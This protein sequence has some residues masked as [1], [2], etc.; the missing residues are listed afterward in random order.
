MG[1]LFV[2]WPAGD[3]SDKT[4]SLPVVN[5]SK[6]EPNETLALSLSAFGA[7]K[8]AP[9]SS[10]L[11]IEDDDAVVSAVSGSGTYGGA[12]TL[13]AT[14]TLAGSP[15][16]GKSVAFT[17]NGVSVGSAATDAGGVATLS[18]VSLSGFNAGAQAGAVGAAFAGDA[19][20]SG[21]SATGPLSVAKA[22]Q[23]INFGALSDKTYGDADFTVSATASSGLSVSFGASGN[24]SVSGST[25]HIT[26]AGSCTITASQP[27]DSNYNAAAGVSRDFNIAQASTSVALS[28]SVNPSAVGQ[29]VT[30]T[31]TV[32]SPAGPAPGGVFGAVNFF[33]DGVAIPNCASL[34]NSGQAA[35]TTSTLTPGSHAITAEYSTTSQNFTGSSGGLQGGQTVGSLIEFAQ[36][37]YGVAEGESLTVTVTR[38][39][40]ASRAVSVDYATDDGSAPGVAVPC[41][42]VTGLALD[43]CDYSK[44]LGTLRFAP[45]ETEKT[46]VVL[47]GD[48][49]YAEGAET[50]SLKLS[51][52]SGG[53]ALG[54]RPA[55]VMTISDDSPE[56]ADS[57]I[58]DDENFVRQHYRDFLHRDPDAAGLAFWTNSIKSCGADAHCR[59]VRRVHAS[60]AFFLSIESQETGFFAY[61][62]YKAA[63]G[64]AASPDVPGAVPVI[65][66]EEFLP[67]AQL[68]GR[69]VIVGQGAWE[70]QLEANKQA[71]ALAFVSRQR[72]A[73][74]FPSTMS[75]AAFVSKL[76]ENAGGV[77]SPEESAR[78][79]AALGAA[80]SDASKRAS[81]FVQVAENAQLRQREF[82]RAFVL[83][84]YFGYLRRNPDDAPE[85]SRNF[86]G[87][88]FWLSKLDEF[89]GDFVQAE[90]VKA[91]ITSDE[92]RRRFG[93]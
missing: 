88:E 6:P 21:A 65:R 38:S 81:V 48:D 1:D 80:P 56:T 84:E 61:R 35:C 51:N 19:D 3:A 63:Y 50:A 25:V 54:P 57:P 58:D 7:T 53:S 59:E 75:A 87:W 89:D 34:L 33:D 23:T 71:F 68:V 39:G 69:D 8:G 46:F 66:F 40:D 49:S 9:A 26:G 76:D 28:S 64:D 15:L 45:G 70:Q 67:D 16:P 92:Y 24:C 60:A 13:E 11:T 18:G 2:T 91:F 74:A 31:A 10:T 52:P 77:L 17:L 73:D 41:S 86:A 90:L 82:S 4:V 27:G 14:L 79:V 83:M 29:S 44:A 5:D 62:A 37:A 72:F 30:F 93:Q 20:V 36:S 22:S 12:A 85:P 78:L 47:G 55:A 42:A 43:R 32:T